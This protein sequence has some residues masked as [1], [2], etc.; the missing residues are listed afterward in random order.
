[1]LDSA[2]VAIIMGIVLGFLSG[3]GIGGGSLLMVWLN[4]VLSWSIQDAR[5]VNLLFFLPSALI[6]CIIRY[7]TGMLNWKTVL[8][9]IIS[10]CLFAVAG[11]A[12]S[13]WVNTITLQKLFGVL[14]ILAGIKEIFY[15]ERKAR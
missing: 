11:N 1:M 5:A 2:P 15:R 12:V 10:G 13:N 4:A 14:L 7:K 9:A 3:L 6:A 8:P